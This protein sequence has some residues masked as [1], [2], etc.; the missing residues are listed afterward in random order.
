MSDDVIFI[1]GSPDV[2][3]K[4]IGACQVQCHNNDAM[5]SVFSILKTVSMTMTFWLLQ[6]SL[7]VS[8]DLRF[9]WFTCVWMDFEKHLKSL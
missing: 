8:D 3:F 6:S 4:I 2:D 1:V 9:E 5:F 7:M